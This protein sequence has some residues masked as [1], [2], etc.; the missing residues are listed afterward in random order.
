MVSLAFCQKRTEAW[1]VLSNVRLNQRMRSG[2]AQ[3]VETAGI[4][5]PLRIAEITRAAGEG[6]VCH[7]AQTG[8]ARFVQASTTTTRPL[9]PVMLNPNRLVR[10]PKLGAL[11]CT[12]AFQSTGGRPTAQ[13][14]P[15]PWSPAV[16]GGRIASPRTR[17]P[18]LGALPLK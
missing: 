18:E 15:S 1:Y 8:L 3:A 16:I 9:V 6:V 14:S 10:T 2:H 12:W 4:I 7:G 5:R 13:R 17:S 11:V